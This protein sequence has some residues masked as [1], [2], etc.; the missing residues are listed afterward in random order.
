MLVWMA[1]PVRDLLNRLDESAATLEDLLDRHPGRHL[2]AE[3]EAT[4]LERSHADS[5]HLPDLLARIEQAVFSLCSGGREGTE[6]LSA[7]HD[8]FG[9]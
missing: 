2:L 7:L 8:G 1:I 3:Y 6:R 9:I 4:V 5:G